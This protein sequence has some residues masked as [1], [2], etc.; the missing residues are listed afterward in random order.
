M[1]SSLTFIIKYANIVE[2][3][4]H[5]GLQPPTHKG[6]TM[7]DSALATRMASDETALSTPSTKHKFV[8]HNRP[9]TDAWACLWVA[10]RFIAK[11][12]EYTVCFVPAGDKLPP[13][14]EVGYKVVY[15]DTGKGYFDQHEKELKRT[16]SCRMLCEGLLIYKDPGLKPII[17]LTVATDNV[18]EVS[19]TSIHYALKGLPYHYKDADTKQ[20]DWEAARIFAFTAFDIIYGQAVE[21]DKNHQLYEKVKEVHELP[22]GLKV[23]NLWN[24]PGLRDAAFKDGSDVV[25]YFVKRGKER[26]YPIIQ[27]GR[28]SN[29]VLDRVMFSL[30]RAE[31]K[32]RNVPTKDQDLWAIGSNPLFGA[33]FFHDSHKMIACG[34]NGHE[35]EKPEEFTQLSL[36]KIVQIVCD[37]LSTIPPVNQ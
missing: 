33:W 29:V 12:D 22:N 32:K 8:T 19:L 15:M 34:T 7:S 21:R 36:S 4:H 10:A 18:E 16:S 28:N 14:E 13:E 26:F 37:E 2:A 31:A 27:V 5:I 6:Y 11:E 24:R 25:C 3:V 20:I 23:V 35:L 17:D 1:N 9:D 30:R